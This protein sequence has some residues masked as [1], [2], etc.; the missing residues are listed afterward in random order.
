M[1]P[2]FH[3]L[4]CGK[5]EVAVFGFVPSSIT[6]CMSAPSVDGCV[7]SAIVNRK[8]WAPIRK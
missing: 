2:V 7:R 1:F 8:G 6:T 5:T 4:A 3:S